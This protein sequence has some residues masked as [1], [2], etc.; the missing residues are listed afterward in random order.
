MGRGKGEKQRRKKRSKKEVTVQRMEGSQGI[1]DN[2]GKYERN[3]RRRVTEP[4]TT[5]IKCA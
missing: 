3:N 2:D 1:R 5:I 4:D